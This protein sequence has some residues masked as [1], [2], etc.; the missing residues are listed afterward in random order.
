MKFAKILAVA[1]LMVAGSAFAQGY[2]GLEFS[3]ETKRSDDSSKGKVAVVVGVKAAGGMDYSL[4]VENSQAKLGDGDI[5]SGVEV[6]AKKTFA[7][8]SA[9]EV[10]P[11]L[12][13]RLG[14]KITGDEHFSHYAVDYGVKFPIIGK[15]V[16]LDLGGRYRNAFNTDNEFRSNRGHALVTYKVTDKDTVGIRYSK[17]YGDVGEEKDAWRLSYTRSF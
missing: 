9:Y 7:A 3:D 10:T 4:K 11:Y 13:V 6:R 14:E 15:V 1:A 2:A 5:T 8:I 12:G 16:Y 17:S